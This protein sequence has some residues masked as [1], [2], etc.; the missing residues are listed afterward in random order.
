M[1]QFEGEASFTGQ[2]VHANQ[3]EKYDFQG[4]NVLCVGLGES[5]ADVSHIIAQQASNC[6][7]VARGHPPLYVATLTII[8]MMPTRPAYHRLWVQA[9]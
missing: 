5:G 4:K 2:I 8:Q 6:T 3:F 9:V 1:P 7:L